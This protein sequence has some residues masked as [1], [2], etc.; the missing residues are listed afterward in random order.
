M[1]IKSAKFRQKFG[2]L[3]TDIFMMICF[4]I[5]IFLVELIASDIFELIGQ[6]YYYFGVTLHVAIVL[7]VAY[8]FWYETFYYFVFEN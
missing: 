1:N 8:T 7:L 4:V 6:Y 3:K 5:A 2:N